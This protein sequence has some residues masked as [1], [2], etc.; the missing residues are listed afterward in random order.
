MSGKEE[1]KYEAWF[2]NIRKISDR[3]K[4]WL[5]AKMDSAE[6][7]YY[8][9][10]K[11]LKERGDFTEKEREAFKEA[12]RTKDPDEEL[13]VMN[14]KG[15]SFYTEASKEY[16]DRLREI[17]SPPY[18]IYVKGELPCQKKPTVSIVGARDCSTY[19]ER[20]AIHFS[21]RLAEEGVQIISGMARGI[22]GAGHRGALNVKG[23]TFAVLGCG[24]DVCYPKENLGLFKDLEREGGLLSEYPPMCQP[25]KSHFPARNRII[26]ALSDA[27]LVME[28]REK[29]GSLITADMALEQG[30]DVY[31]LPGPITSNLSRG[32]H[33]L[34]RQG[35]GILISPEDFLKEKG[36]FF[37]DSEGIEKRCKKEIRL[38]R[39]EN[40]LYSCLDLYPKNLDILLEETGIE[41]KQLT[42]CLVSMEMK[43]YIKEVSKNHYVRI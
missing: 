11:E 37:H 1:E 25:F 21:E 8:I 18:A 29:S 15:I 10:E 35:A 5:R 34:I 42:R 2:A 23:K 28:A 6:A 36:W 24:V 27:V 43:G 20:M 33:E 13:E 7:I 31:A 16:P 4:R 38:E 40:M 9:E 12:R 32:C 22:D 39:T 41:P 17:P 26:S 30:K 14:E 3:K 19:G